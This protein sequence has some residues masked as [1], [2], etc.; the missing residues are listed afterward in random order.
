MVVILKCPNHGLDSWFTNVT[1]CKGS[2]PPDT[3]VCMPE[4]LDQPIHIHAARAVNEIGFFVV[5]QAV[6]NHR[7]TSV[8]SCSFLLYSLIRAGEQRMLPFGLR[9]SSFL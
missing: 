6:G 7:F 1:Q 8:L 4:R 3:E 9:Q 2:P 5:N